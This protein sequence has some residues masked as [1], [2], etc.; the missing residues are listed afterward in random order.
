MAGVEWRSGST[1][2]TKPVGSQYYGFESSLWQSL[3]SR[4][5]ALHMHFALQLPR[6]EHSDARGRV[7]N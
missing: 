4:P 6:R 2:G 7:A 3:P 5:A 1:V